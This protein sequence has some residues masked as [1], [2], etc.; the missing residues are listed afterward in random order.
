MELASGVR[1]E[2][3]G[4]FSSLL[5]LDSSSSNEIVA[6]KCGVLGVVVALAFG[7]QFMMPIFIFNIHSFRPL[8]YLCLCIITYIAFR[9]NQV[10]WYFLV[11]IIA[12]FVHNEYKSGIGICLVKVTGSYNPFLLFKC[13]SSCPRIGSLDLCLLCCMSNL[14]FDY[15]EPG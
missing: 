15:L 8:P 11:M 3:V 5:L 4:H 10:G 2:L 13:D 9:F 12:Y 1:V 14:N 7:R 6:G